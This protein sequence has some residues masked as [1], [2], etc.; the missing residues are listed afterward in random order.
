MPFSMELFASSNKEGNGSLFVCT[1]QCPGRAVFEPFSV[2][3]R[4]LLSG[5]FTL[6]KPHYARAACFDMTAME[7]TDLR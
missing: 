2:S 6:R 5:R 7:K 1:S 4:M 3:S